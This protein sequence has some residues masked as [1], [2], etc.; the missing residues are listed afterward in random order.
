M[1]ME[2]VKELIESFFSKLDGLAKTE[3]V[4]GD[5][6][7]VQGKTIIPLVE[8]SVGAGG[9][10]CEGNGKKG[11]DGGT[12]GGL[13]ITPVAIICIDESGVSAYGIG[14]K[15]GFLGQIAEMMPH[16]MEK[17]AELKSKCCEQ[18]KED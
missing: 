7:E 6:I 17:C 14:E 12:G 18:E 9:G 15:K 4:I 8:L 13:K 2:H 11:A 1:M 5:P 16:M 10:G 3:T